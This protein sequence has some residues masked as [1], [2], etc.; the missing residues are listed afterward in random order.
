MQY[1]AAENTTLNVFVSPMKFGLRIFHDSH[2]SV[3][4]SEAEPTIHTLEERSV[5]SVGSSSFLTNFT[6]VAVDSHSS[7]QRLF[8]W[9]FL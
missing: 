7:E 6:E 9:I 1:T 2:G 3:P 8:V 5:P 4:R